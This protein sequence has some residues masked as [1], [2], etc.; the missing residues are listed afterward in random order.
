MVSNDAYRDETL[1]P[2][3]RHSRVGGNPVARSAFTGWAMKH[4]GALFVR[5][6]NG[7][8][9]PLESRLCGNDGVGVK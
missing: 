2:S 8:C 6:L 4:L 1:L 9:A 5:T 7:A 3:A